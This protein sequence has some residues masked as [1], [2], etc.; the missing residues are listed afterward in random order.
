MLS[1]NLIIFNNSKKLFLFDGSNISVLDSSNISLQLFRVNDSV[2]VQKYETGLKKFALGQ[3]VN[4]QNGEKLMGKFIESILSYN[5]S[6]LIKY[7]ESPNFYVLGK[8]GLNKQIFGFE[9]YIDKA[10]FSDAIILQGNNIAISTKSAGLITFNYKWNYIQN[11]GVNEGLLDNTVNNLHAD[12]AGNLWV[13]HDVGISRIELNMPVT[14]YGNFAGISG[15]IH[16]II[17][18]KSTLYLATSNGLLEGTF[19]NIP[20][21]SNFKRM[22]FNRLESIINECFKLVII[23][24]KLFAITPTGIYYIVDNNSLLIHKENISCF[25]ESYY[26]N[27]Q[28]FI[29]TDAGLKMLSYK[30]GHFYSKQIYPLN[31]NTFI[32]LAE[33][34]KN[35]AWFKTA[36]NGLGKIIFGTTDSI[37]KVEI[38]NSYSGLPKLNRN[39]HLLNTPKGIAFCFPDSILKYNFKSDKFQREEVT[40]LKYLSGIPWLAEISNDKFG[41]RWYQLSSSIENLQGILLYKPISGTN[42]AKPYFFYTGSPISPIYID[43]SIVWIGGDNKLL[44]FDNSKS[45]NFPRD[46]SA[47]IKRVLI[48]ND[49]L[50]KIGLEDP[51]ISYKYNTLKF[52]V[53]STCFEGEPYVRYQYRLKGLTKNW[54]NWSRQSDI[55]FSDL[56]PGE[57][58]FQIKALNVDGIV[59]DVTELKFYVLHPFYLTYPAYAIYLLLL[60][61]ATF[62]LLRWRTWRFFKYKEDLERIVQERTEEIL[63]EKE[64]SELLIANMFPKGTADELKQTGKASSQKFSMATVLFSDIQ[65]FTKIAEQMNPEL[66]IDQLDA[67]FFHFDMVVEKYNIEKIKTIGDAYMCAGGIPNKNITNPVEVVL[68]AM[69]MQEYMKE[70]K[71]QNSDIW[72]LRIGIHTG[73]VIAGV[74]GHK[75][76]SYDIWGDTVNTAS[77]MESSGEPGKVN[78]SGHTYE[79]VKDFF[80]C[81]YRGKMPV[82]YKGEIDMYFVKSIRPELALDMRQIPNKKFFI[83]LQLLRIQDVEEEVMEKLKKELPVNLYFHNAA[84]VREIY[85]LVDLFGRAEELTDEEN[86]IVRTA[87]L[88][89]DIGYIGSYD[90]H[91]ENSIKFA[92]ELLVQ[93]KYSQDQIDKVVELI[94]ATM[95][96][97]KPKNKMEEILIDADMNYLSRADFVSLNDLYFMELLE[98]GKV[99]SKEIWNKEQIVLLSNHKY[100]TKVANVLRDVSP[101]LQIENLIEYSQKTEQTNL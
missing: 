61:F 10:G 77:R 44:Q 9:D 15:K 50:L 28:Y 86:L 52:L 84:R 93:F 97:R 80:V 58:I 41:N 20:G 99:E 38:L 57:Y 37:T 51:E 85:N 66:L 4:V 49:S 7:S 53:S 43:S 48:G 11:I 96:L 3:I 71:G 62:I 65:G 13:L 17:K 60:L 101:E 34:T 6:L 45:F 14:S 16:D 36:D 21:T 100:Y 83:M 79:L 74:V 2:Y 46:F 87:A 63:K 26:H 27:N 92:R 69:E 72:D 22:Y 42:K 30:D 95:R 29:S 68:A 25:T 70:L 59:S 64:K 98:R 39:Y 82:K 81:E 73:S 94:E 78:I 91:E 88:L 54:S 76:L 40:D 90:S 19:K 32:E 18:F 67:F 23:E 31:G 24:N 33:E 12:K 56:P 47:I 55:L 8:D 35:L 5:N 89:H 75:K 1:M